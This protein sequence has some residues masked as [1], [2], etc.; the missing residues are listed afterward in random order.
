MP[1]SDNRWIFSIIINLI[2]GSGANLRKGYPRR[3]NSKPR[4]SPDLKTEH[5][6]NHSLIITYGLTHNI[7][8]NK[9]RP[10]TQPFTTT[11][12]QCMI[13]VKSLKN[14]TT[15]ALFNDTHYLFLNKSYNFLFSSL[16]KLF[17]LIFNL[18][19]TS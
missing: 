3:H 6:F 18:S 12:L 13:V 5:I 8:S 1:A 15:K 10:R 14:R 2:P 19:N 7:H 17:P 16:V 9:A 11:T 4:R